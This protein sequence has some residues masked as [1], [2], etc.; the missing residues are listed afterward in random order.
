MSIKLPDLRTVIAYNTA[1]SSE[2]K[3]HDDAVAKQFGFSGGL[4][5]GVDVYAYMTNPAVRHWG[6]EWLARGTMEVRFLKPAYEGEEAH[7]NARA[8]GDDDD[9]LAITVVSRGE[10]CA[11]GTARVPKDA[12][13]APE[14]AA[15]PDRPLPASL[16][17]AS[18]RSLPDGVA[19]GT[20]HTVYDEALAPQYLADVRED[21]TLYG[22]QG[23]VHP[24][25]L[26]RLG[27]RVL[28]KNVR[29]GPWI[30]V[31]SE[32]R[33]FAVAEVG[34]ALAARARV[35]ATYERKGHAFV[36]LDVLALKADGSPLLAI[37]H[38]AIYAPR[39]IAA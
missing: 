33:H 30:H 17:P 4:V 38:T 2:N 26:L 32:V 8:A 11:I 23:I 7:I 15:Y 29:L 6:P 35:I 25:F 21:L 28:S 36:D 20:F 19:L 3:I 22:D 31:G 39:K 10:T 37:K 24:G 9:E 18:P 1:K 5:P 34:E 16:A 13:A 27:N 12:G 14:P